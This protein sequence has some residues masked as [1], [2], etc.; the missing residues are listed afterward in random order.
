SGT[1]KRHGLADFDL[2]IGRA[3]VVFLLRQSRCHGQREC[4]RCAGG[5][6]EKPIPHVDAF[7]VVFRWILPMVLVTAA[8]KQRQAPSLAG[9]VAEAMPRCKI[10]KGGW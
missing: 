9:I 8:G 1:R 7:L 5:Q 2:G 6:V 10:T 4:Q 3:S